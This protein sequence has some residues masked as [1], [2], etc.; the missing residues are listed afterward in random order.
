MK[1]HFL[2]SGSAKGAAR[3]SVDLPIL[4][5]AALM[6]VVKGTTDTGQTLDEADIGRVRINRGGRQIQGETFEFYHDHANLK[7]GFPTRTVGAATAS[8]IVAFIPFFVP[9]LRNTLDIRSKEEVDVYLDFD[10]VLNTR[11]GANAGTYELYVLEA[12]GTPE[13]Y[14]LHVEE[15]DLVASGSGRLT[16]I[17]DG[18]NIA[19]VYYRDPDSVVDQ[20]QLIVDGETVVDNID[21][22][23]ILDVTQYENRI[24]SSGIGLLETNLVPGGNIAEGINGNVRINADF[25]GAGDLEITKFRVLR[26]RRSEQSI[27][28]VTNLL[29]GRG[30]AAQARIRSRPAGAVG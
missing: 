10:A 2:D 18:E 19:Q 1:T 22:E 5:A 24:E 23:A 4:R 28:D 26:S 14:E 8:R 21:D 7:G 16:D 25:S 9:G 3:V 11:F 20:I 12:E 17:L 29:S 13:T 6:L 15:Q 30:L 27:D